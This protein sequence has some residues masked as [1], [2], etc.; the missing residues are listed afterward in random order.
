MQTTR[1]FGTRESIRKA[2]ERLTKK[3]S[4]RSSGEEFR[5]LQEIEVRWLL[6]FS[7]LKLPPDADWEV[8]GK[9]I[10]LFAFRLIGC[11]GVWPVSEAG[12]IGFRI[13][14]GWGAVPREFPPVPAE[15]EIRAFHAQL[16]EILNA[17]WSGSGEH[18]G[19]LVRIPAAVQH[20]Y[21]HLTLDSRGIK[22]IYG[23]GWPAWL[24]LAVAAVLEEFG[25][26]I[27]RCQAPHCGRLFLRIRRQAY[28]SVECSQ[29][30]RSRRWY[31]A[32]QNEARDRRRD[33]YERHIRQK[34]PGANIRV[35][36]RGAT[37]GPEKSP[38]VTTSRRKK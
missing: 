20:V 8:L 34:Y 29:R 22:R 10:L 16:R 12:E 9:R 5:Q 28:C 6:A 24:W 36:S 37:K 3:Q 7:A 31:E 38:R 30:V 23:S 35:A 18:P 14:T 25:S 15:G 19:G 32:H 21:L 4:S 11:G 2:F 1:D 27:K 33:A 17:L 26:H 13:V